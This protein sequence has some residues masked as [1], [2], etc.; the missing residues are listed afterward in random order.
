[1]VLAV[2]VLA[3]HELALLCERKGQQL[4]YPVAIVAVC[5]YVV[6][7]AFDLLHKWE[8]VLLAGIVIA[9]F[10]M[11]M[12]GAQKGYFARTAYT[13]LAVL[14]IGKLLS[15]FVMIRSVPVVGIAYTLLVVVFIASTDIMAMAVG[16]AIGRHPLTTISPKKTIEGS[17]GAFLIVSALGYAAS[18]YAPLH[19]LAWQGI[20]IAAVT[21]VA[22]QA[23]DLVESALKRDAGVKDTGTIIHGH[24]GVL[25]RFD[26]YLFGGMAFFGM[27][28]FVGIL[29][30]Q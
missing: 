5:A 18:W 23:G 7:A 19:L 22:A 20:A 13:L 8:G 24:G 12:Y 11:G 4:E 15:Y 9:S 3:L 27:L 10:W 16:S 17:A 21:S 28:H 2:G 25:D 1:M 14:Y 26:S 6:F 30:V 29:S